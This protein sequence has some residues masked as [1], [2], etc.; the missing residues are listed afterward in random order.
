[1]TDE[2]KFVELMTSFGVPMDIDSKSDGTIEITI[3]KQ[4]PDTPKIVGYNGFHS[5]YT[6]NPKGEFVSVGNW[7]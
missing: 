1:M 6:F 3:Q 4:T 5:I 2:R 7:E